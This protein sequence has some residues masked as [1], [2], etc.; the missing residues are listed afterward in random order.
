ME[1]HSSQLKI[2]TVNCQM[3]GLGDI[4]KRR[5]VFKIKYNIYFL[6]DT[7]F[8]LKD[9]NFIRTQYGRKAFFCSYKSYSRGVEILFNDNC[10]LKI[11]AEIQYKYSSYL[12]LDIIVENIHFL[13]V[14]IFGS[15]IDNPTSFCSYK[16][17]IKGRCNS[18]K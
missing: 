14:N 17:N 16:F 5:D 12:I 10:D 4:N 6:Q 11:N 15:N 7:H 13:L 2:L 3:Q 8:V 9:E 18:F 1:I